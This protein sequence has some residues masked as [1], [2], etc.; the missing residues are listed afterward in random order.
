M[1]GYL[2][3]FVLSETLATKLIRQH[4]LKCECTNATPWYAALA[5]IFCNIIFL[6]DHMQDQTDIIMA[7]Q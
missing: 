3:A 1:V 5:R 2:D 6:R 4:M 7:R